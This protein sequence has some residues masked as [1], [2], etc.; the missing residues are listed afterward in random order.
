MCIYLEKAMAPHSSALAWKIPWTEEPGGL[1]S[2]GSRRIGLSDFTLPFQFHALEKEMA[3]HSSVLAWRIPG[4]GQPGGLP[5]VGSHRVGHDW[6]DLAAATVHV[7]LSSLNEIYTKYDSYPSELT[8]FSLTVYPRLLSPSSGILSALWISTIF[9]MSLQ[10]LDII[11][12][13]CYSLIAFLYFI[14][15]C[16]EDVFQV[17]LWI[18]NWNF[19]NVSSTHYSQCGFYFDN[20]DSFY[21]D[22]PSTYWHH[23]TALLL[24][25]RINVLF[26]YME[27]IREVF[28]DVLFCFYTACILDKN[29]TSEY[30]TLNF[31]LSLYTGNW[32][33][34]FLYYYLVVAVY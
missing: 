16:L 3:A 23:W 5:S 28:S 22:F 31:H 19:Y 12:F 18:S 21:A 11:S 4:T 13:K 6:S 34:F 24:M 15:L 27:I 7:C 29:E 25:E 30:F 8:E 17:S 26:C 9:K 20:H 2:T 33:V 14:L 32:R 10:D 1:P